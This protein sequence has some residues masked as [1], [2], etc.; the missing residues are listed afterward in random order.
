MNIPKEEDLEEQKILAP[1]LIREDFEYEKSV[2]P[3]D[4][5][6][7]EAEMFHATCNP[8]N[9]TML[10][11]HG[12]A[13]TRYSVC[14]SIAEP[15]EAR[16]EELTSMPNG[17]K[18]PIYPVYRVK[19]NMIEIYDQRSPSKNG[20]AREQNAQILSARGQMFGMGQGGSGSFQHLR[21]NYAMP[22]M[23]GQAESK[24]KRF[25]VL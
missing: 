16:L 8:T 6:A 11:I 5:N 1:E 13:G 15:M 19:R 22:E 24:K 2:I 23:P 9:R 25:G 4:T 3:T 21:E 7:A 14:S 17:F 18:K 10:L 12:Y 20:K